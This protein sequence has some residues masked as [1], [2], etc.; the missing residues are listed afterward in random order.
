MPAEDTYYTPEQPQQRLYER[1]FRHAL[2]SPEEIQAEEARIDLFDEDDEPT[3]VSYLSDRATAH[4]ISSRPELAPEREE[5]AEVVPFGVAHI[6]TAG[7]NIV[8]H[9]RAA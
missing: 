4:A 1:D 5:T 2:L 3:N 7:A 8:M 9:R 6:K